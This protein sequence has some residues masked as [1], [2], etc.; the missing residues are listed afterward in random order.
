MIG[1][2]KPLIFQ[3][4][5]GGEKIAQQSRRVQIRRRAPA[6]LEHLRPARAAQAIL[7]GPQVDQQQARRLRQIELC[8]ERA[9]RVGDRRERRD[10]E[11]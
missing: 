9:A 4:A 1:E 6:L 5:H 11:R 10:D 2:Q 8:G 3:L 7:A